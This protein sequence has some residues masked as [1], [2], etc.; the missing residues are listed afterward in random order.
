MFKI[1]DTLEENI[2]SWL[3]GIM[4]VVITLQVIFRYFVSYSL[5]WPEELGRYL[6][7]ASVYIGASYVEQKDK[8]L[9]ITILRT[10]GG[11]WCKKWIPIIVHIITIIFS[12]LMTVWGVQMVM[13]MY[14]TNQ[15]APAIE[16]P[17][18]IVYASI[19]L[20]MAGMAVRSAINLQKDMRNNSILP[21]NS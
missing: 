19:P 13:F 12:I 20:G 4:T 9:A 21:P 8:H 15:L 14:A 6:F 3:L 5:A 2:S 1:L 18:Y 17:M 7:I 10:N 11:A 16:V